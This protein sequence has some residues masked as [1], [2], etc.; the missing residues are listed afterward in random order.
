[1]PEST[2]TRLEAHTLML[3]Y[4]R[5]LEHRKKLAQQKE[6]IPGLFGSEEILPGLLS[7]QQQVP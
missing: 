2:A 1:M 4:S 6:G 7:W 3:P 5:Q